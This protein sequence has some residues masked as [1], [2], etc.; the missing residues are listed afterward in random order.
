[1]KY[2]MQLLAL[3][4]VTPAWGQV[5]SDTIF[6]SV[7]GTP[8][9]ALLTAEFDTPFYVGDTATFMVEVMDE[10]GQPITALISFFSTDTTMLRIEP[11]A[12]DGGAPSSVGMAV[13]IA[14]RRD[15]VPVGVWAVA[16]PLGELRVATYRGDRLES[17]I[18]TGT[19]ESAPGD[20]T[21]WEPESRWVQGYQFVPNP[22]PTLQAC[23]YLL[24][25]AG[26]LIAQ[27]PEGCPM[28]FPPALLPNPLTHLARRDLTRREFFRLAEGLPINAVT[29]GE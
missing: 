14:L 27:E 17:T 23:A 8:T 29:A 13:G 9:A 26:D 16:E 11:V 10:A 19:W 28:A 21:W 22:D 25:P 12:T 24:N 20:S 2:L 5:V 7:E 3:L 4:L 15:T 6:I 18:E 1:M